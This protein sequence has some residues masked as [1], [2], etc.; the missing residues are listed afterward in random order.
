MVWSQTIAFLAAKLATGPELE[1]KRTKCSI[2]VSVA[3]KFHLQIYKDWEIVESGCQV[4]SS[5]L[6][7]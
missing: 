7:S 3:C 1:F 6:N 2:I 4:I 5:C